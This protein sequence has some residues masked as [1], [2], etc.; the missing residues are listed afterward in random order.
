M[1]LSHWPYPRSSAWAGVKKPAARA[2]VAVT[3]TRSLRMV[4]PSPS[5]R[6]AK[7]NGRGCPD[8]VSRQ[9]PGRLPQPP[10]AP[11]VEEVAQQPSRNHALLERQ[12]LQVAVAD[13]GG[14]EGRYV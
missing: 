7:P 3:E 13:R 10:G 12:V 9:A 14:G 5:R 6:A 11:V 4:T 1:P 8:L 2:S